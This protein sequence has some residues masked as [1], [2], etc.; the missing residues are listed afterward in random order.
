MKMGIEA[1]IGHYWTTNLIKKHQKSS[2]LHLQLGIGMPLP[3]V[4]AAP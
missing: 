1:S 4:G 2:N 3:T